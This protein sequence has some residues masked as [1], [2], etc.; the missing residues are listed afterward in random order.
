M[1]SRILALTSTLCLM[2]GIQATALAADSIT[3]GVVP[4][5]ILAPTPTPPGAGDIP[6]AIEAIRQ[7]GSPADAVTAYGRGLALDRNNV[8]LHQAYLQRMVAFDLPDVAAYAAQVIVSTQPD[9]GLAWAVTASGAAKRGEMP[10]AVTDVA[11]AASLAPDDAYVLRTVGQVLAWYDAA[12]DRAAVP[13]SIAKTLATLRPQLEA[14]RIYA[15][16][17]KQSQAAYLA[18]TPPAPGPAPGLAPG[19]APTPAPGLAPAPGVSGAPTGAVPASTGGDVVPAPVPAPGAAPVPIPG[20]APGYGPEPSAAAS[21]RDWLYS[22][23]SGSW[24]GSQLF[25]AASAHAQAVASKEQYDQAQHH[26]DQTL[27]ELRHEVESNPPL[28]AARDETAKADR[29][30]QLARAKA[31]QSLKTEKVY[32]ERVEARAGAQAELD[33]RHAELA[34]DLAMDKDRNAD[35]VKAHQAARDKVN[36]QIVAQS[37]R[38]LELSEQIQNLEDAVLMVDAGA[39]DARAAWQTATARV[40]D[41][42]RRLE[43]GRLHDPRLTGAMA[44]VDAARTV[45]LASDAYNQGVAQAAEAAADYA[46]YTQNNQYRIARVQSPYPG[47][48]F[49]TYP[50]GWQRPWWRR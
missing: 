24:P 49:T 26:L 7:A 1:T 28:V 34:R 20:V 22:M 48:L 39:T 45:W 2:G 18:R 25:E 35:Q 30:L 32:Q 16:A 15:D 19:P 14:N 3:P 36:D 6:S 50:Y 47:P 40:V 17:Y 33:Q 9:S 37:Q 31:L 21:N 42:Q 43:N 5:P 23:G 12:P 29:V 46:Y 27:E 38:V 13:A 44:A 41:L 10:T 11:M 8:R 4:A